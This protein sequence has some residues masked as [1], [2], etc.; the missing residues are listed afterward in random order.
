MRRK[1]IFNTFTFHLTQI[2][3][4]LGLINVGAMMCDVEWV[5]IDRVNWR[6]RFDS[7]RCVYLLPAVIYDTIRGL[8]FLCKNQKN[9]Q[10]LLFNEEH[11]LARKL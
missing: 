7:P 4:I 8:K 10:K 11:F 5:L 1:S 9:T 6:G 2:E 3:A